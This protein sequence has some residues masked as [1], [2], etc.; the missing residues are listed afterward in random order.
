[1]PMQPYVEPCRAQLTSAQVVDLLQASTAV[2][3]GGGMEIVDIGLNVI[4]DIS[5]DFS[6]GTV[7]RNSYADMHASLNFR[8]TRELDW[9][10]GLVRPYITVADSL[11]TAKFYLGVYHTSIPAYDAS[12]SPPTFDVE[13]YDLLLR[14][15]QPVG[16]AYAIAL[17]QGYLST[18]E[19]ILIARGFTQYIINQSAADTISPSARTWTM[20]D[21]ITW[22]TVV[23]DLLSS[24]GY[25]GIWSDWN[26]TLRCEPYVL[27]S[28]RSIEWTY[29]DDPVTTMLG[30]QRSVLRDFF[31]APNRWVFYRSNS[32]DDVAPVEG[33]GLYIAEN[34][35][36][37]ETSIDARGGLVITKVTGVDVANQTA[38]V[39]TALVA[40][41]RERDIP[42][43]ITVQTFPNPLH[44]HFDRLYLRDSGTVPY[45]DL[46]C[47]EWSLPIP[48]EVG[49]MQQTW[50][51]I[52]Q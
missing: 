43:I 38:L 46:Q 34:Q 16:D 42:T 4:E 20:D 35:S 8:I 2:R 14:L 30:I 28:D 50:R 27:P 26:G 15:N 3:L 44:W 37:G 48:P 31:D 5:D 24:V 7:T 51:V 18:V 52:A 23:N 19:S 9:G 25:A 41:A 33:N 21:N 17:G 11:R 13:G 45:A 6:G 12:E 22:L 47:T 40:I 36:V 10:G 29:S 1:M 32:S 49:D 39:A